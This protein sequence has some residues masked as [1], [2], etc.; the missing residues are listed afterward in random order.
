MKLW[1]K[2]VSIG[3]LSIVYTDG[4]LYGMIGIYAIDYRVI[5]FLGSTRNYL[6]PLSA[7]I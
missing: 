6:C 7:K 3:V 1:R 5:G 2:H 4:L